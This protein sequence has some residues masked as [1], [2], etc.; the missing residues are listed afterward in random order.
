MYSAL[1][2]Q[3]I[4]KKECLYQHSPCRLTSPERQPKLTAP[5]TAS[6]NGL[7]VVYGTDDHS[8]SF[9]IFPFIQINSQSNS[10][11]PAMK[12]VALNFLTLINIL[13]PQTIFLHPWHF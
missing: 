11:F 4:T 2:A 8:R 9:R 5:S 10:Q 1:K 13:F 12:H 3:E 6:D 7:T